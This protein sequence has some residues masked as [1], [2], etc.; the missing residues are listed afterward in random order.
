MLSACKERALPS[1][2]FSRQLR[3]PALPAREAGVLL[4]R[5]THKS[6]ST[7]AL[8][9]VCSVRLSAGTD[10]LYSAALVPPLLQSM[11]TAAWISDNWPLGSST[12]GA[13]AVAGEGAGACEIGSVSAGGSKDHHDAVAPCL[14][15]LVGL[16]GA[17]ASLLAVSPAAADSPESADES[18]SS[19]GA[20]AEVDAP[21]A[22]RRKRCTLYFAN[23]IR[24]RETHAFF[25]ALA[26]RVFSPFRQLS[27]KV[28][29]AEVADSGVLI[30]EG[31]LRLDWSLNPSLP[32]V[33]ASLHRAAAEIKAASA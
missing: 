15:Q 30:W 13:A 10:V 16:I 23:E 3:C 18:A 9:H 12:G 19:G 8:P 20:G 7:A 24:C 17:V 26:E 6:H 28:V 25:L 5:P 33:L 32:A 21:A 27:R 4:P 31:R 14:T 1:H 11:V 29:G 2:K 22:P